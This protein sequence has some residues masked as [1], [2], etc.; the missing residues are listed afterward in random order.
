MRWCESLHRTLKRPV[1]VEL[2]SV[3]LTFTAIR[4][5]TVFV[6]TSKVADVAP[7]GT[8]TFAGTA[9]VS[10][11]LEVS[12]T[13]LSPGPEGALSVTVPTDAAPPRTLFGLNLRRTTVSGAAETRTV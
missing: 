4:F 7:A 13:V 1:L 10:G 11:L 6:V 2:P 3:A 9:T 8:T 5:R 12:V